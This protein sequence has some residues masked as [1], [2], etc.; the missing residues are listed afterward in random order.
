MLIALAAVTAGCNG[1]IAAEG[2]GDASCTSADSGSGT[3]C[4][5]HYDFRN[6]GQPY[7]CPAGQ[8]C[9]FWLRS[10]PKVCVPVRDDAGCCPDCLVVATAIGDPVRRYWTSVC[11]PPTLTTSNDPAGLPSNGERCLGP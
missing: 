10:W 4:D 7:G 3:L 1:L 9:L 6:G 2:E 5:L 8:I 11:V